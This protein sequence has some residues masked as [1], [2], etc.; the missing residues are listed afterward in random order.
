MLKNAC[1][2]GIFPPRFCNVGWRISAWLEIKFSDLFS[3]MVLGNSSEVF[4]NE[5][6]LSS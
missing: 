6:H 3:K 5:I 1:H 2:I 4:N